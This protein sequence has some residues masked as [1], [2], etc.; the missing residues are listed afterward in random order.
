MLTMLCLCFSMYLWFYVSFD[1]DLSHSEPLF[2]CVV[3]SD[4]MPRQW[5]AWLY[6]NSL[7]YFI[8]V[9]G[10]VFYYCF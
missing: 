6:L 5:L 10:L 2:G 7:V 9:V 3:R 8:A 1:M 4:I